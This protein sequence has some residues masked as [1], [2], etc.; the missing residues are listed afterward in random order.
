MAITKKQLIKALEKI[1]DEG[2]GHETD[3][4]QA[5]LLLL[6]YINDTAVSDAFADI[7]KWYA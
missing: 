4:R 6:E 3:H 7:E 5:D 1:A 2:E